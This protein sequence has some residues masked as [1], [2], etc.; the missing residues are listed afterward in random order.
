MIKT[1]DTRMNILLEPED[2]VYVPPT[3]LAWLGLKIQELLF[4][5]SSVNVAPGIAGVAGVPGGVGF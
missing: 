4:P 2:I 5:V 1:G 3:P